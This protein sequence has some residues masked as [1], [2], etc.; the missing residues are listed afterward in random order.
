[1]NVTEVFLY[2]GQFNWDAISTISNIFLVFVLVSITGWYAS[3]VRKQTKLMVI[4]QKRDKIL[5]EVQ[6]VLTPII[7]CLATEFKAIENKKISWHR[8]TSG[9]CGFDW[10]LTRLFYNAQYGSVISV[11]AEKGS[12]ALKDVLTKFSELNRMFSSHDFLIDELNELYVELENEIKIPK[13]KERLIKMAQEFDKGK[14]A[15]YRLNIENP[16]L[17]FSEYIIN[18]EETR[19]RIPNSIDPTIDFL[20]ENQE[21]LLKFR[22]APHIIE[23]SKQISGKLIQLNELDETIFN[24]VEKIREKYRKTYNFT[25][26]E[27]ES[28]QG[29]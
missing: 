4:A 1:M 28:F 27:V 15:T 6:Y 21:E 19:E 13:I 14:S 2:L 25:D 24:A 23:I 10:G 3:E 12:G 22:D 26:S 7:Y 9:V 11:F 16:D 5:E 8:Y 17:L 29:I 18:I 20:E